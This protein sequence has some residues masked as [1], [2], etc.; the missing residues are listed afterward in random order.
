MLSP[1]INLA[2]VWATGSRLFEGQ[3]QL[4]T[5]LRNREKL[6]VAPYL[7]SF[8]THTH[9][10]TWHLCPGY[11]NLVC[12]SLHMLWNL[13][14]CHVRTCQLNLWARFFPLYFLLTSESWKRKSC[15]SQLSWWENS[16][17]IYFLKLIWCN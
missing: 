2:Q 17:R 13:S 14:D 6:K 3:V 7:S 15:W 16:L 1:W 11:L 9:L 5:V 8:H 12:C 10:C 4:S